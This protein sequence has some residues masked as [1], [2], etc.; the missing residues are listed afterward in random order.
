M[1][2]HVS[3][4]VPTLNRRSALEHVLPTL[5]CQSFD[6]NN[7]EILLCDAGSTDGTRELTDSLR[8]PNLDLVAVT[9]S[10]RA[11]ARN[12][13]IRRSQGRIVLFSDADILADPHLIEE[14]V[15]THER[16]ERA[17][18]VGWEVQVASLDEYRRAE[19]DPAARSRLH[20]PRERP[21]SWL[22]FLTGNASVRRDAL[23]EAG[24]FDESF[25][26]YGHE[27]LELGYRLQRRGTRIV[28]QPRAVS[29][30]WHPET[31]DNRAAKKR[32]SGAATIRFYRKHRD[33]RILARLGVNPLSLGWQALLPENGRI[34]RALTARAPR[35]RLCRAIVLEH[36]YLSGVREAMA[37]SIRAVPGERRS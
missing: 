9:H 35:S 3:V 29:Y 12:A 2:I 27:D 18:V 25:T 4:V 11:A 1:P 22:F 13:G 21:I 17:A 20:P 31:V 8:I 6:R 7:Y 10:G 30:H 34:I 36:A 15:R 14:H 37:G 28:Y 26:A 32:L 19:T 16:Y 23:V 33:W 24:M 5:A